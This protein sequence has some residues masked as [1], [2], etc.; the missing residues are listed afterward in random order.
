MYIRQ[1]ETK[2]ESFGIHSVIVANV[3]E[4]ARG[5]GKESVAF[6]EVADN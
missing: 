2:S 5:A 6:V 4:H 1:T 3:H